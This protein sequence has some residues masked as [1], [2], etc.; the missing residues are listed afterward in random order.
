MYQF[1]PH[2]RDNVDFFKKIAATKSDRRKNDLLK[3][4]TA[5][6]ILGLVEICANI[7]KFNF[8]LNK[9]QKRRLAKY[10]EF[11]RSVA[12]SRTEKSARKRLQEGSG[13]A[14]GAILI[15]VLSVLAQHLLEKVI[16]PA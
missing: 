12:R 2:I 15:P 7:L 3:E 9:H 1:T 13:V 16:S 5:D 10:A 11:Y 4:A 14:L 6:Q 8:T